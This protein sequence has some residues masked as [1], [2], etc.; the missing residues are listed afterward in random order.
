MRKAAAPDP[1]FPTLVSH[2]RRGLG[3]ADSRHGTAAPAVM[4]PARVLPTIGANR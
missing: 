3:A 2:G 1:T 4:N